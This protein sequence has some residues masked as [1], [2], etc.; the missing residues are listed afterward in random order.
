[1]AVRANQKRASTGL[2]QPQRG[3]WNLSG[4]KIGRRVE[5]FPARLGKSRSAGNFSAH[6]RE[7]PRNLTGVQNLASPF[8]GKIMN[9]A[10]SSVAARPNPGANRRQFGQFCPCKWAWKIELD[11]FLQPFRRICRKGRMPGCFQLAVTNQGQAGRKCPGPAVWQPISRAKTGPRVSSRRG[12]K[13]LAS[14]A[15]DG[16]SASSIFKGKDRNTQSSLR[17]PRHDTPCAEP[18]ARGFQAQRRY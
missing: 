15:S 12:V 10:N 14:N 17:Q 13:A 3:F 8:G 18:A 1:V 4:A 9:S 7:L 11:Q 5:I 6:W 2:Q 16:F